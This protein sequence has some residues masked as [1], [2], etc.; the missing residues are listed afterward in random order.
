MIQRHINVSQSLGFNSLCRIHHKHGSVTGSQRPAH[1]IIKIHV[2]G[3]INQ[4][5]NILFPVFGLV[6]GTYSLGFDGN[7]PLPFQIHIIQHLFLHFPAGQKAGL[8]NDPVRQCRFSVINMGNNTDIPD[9]TLIY[10]H[11]IP[12][13]LLHIRKHM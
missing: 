4:V 7:A 13:T 5:E 12:P 11:K 3:R 2:A 9:F 10:R 1:L 6:Y 8:F